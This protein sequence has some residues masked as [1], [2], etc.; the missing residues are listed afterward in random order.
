MLMQSISNKC[1]SDGLSL[2]SGEPSNFTDPIAGQNSHKDLID[3]ANTVP[4]LK[5]FKHYNISCNQAFNIIRCPF[6]I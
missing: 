6:Y 5:I 3:L 4:M 2:P 1:G